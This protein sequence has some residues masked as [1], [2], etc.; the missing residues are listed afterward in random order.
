[1]EPIAKE[2]RYCPEC[3]KEIIGRADKTFCS[4]PCRNNYNN[5][6]NKD[7][8]NL[9]R[10]I[11]NALRRNYKIMEELNVGVRATT[12]RKV[13]LKKKFDFSVYTSILEAKTGKTYYVV[14][15]LVYQELDDDVFLIFQSD[16]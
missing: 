6:I 14:Y 1:M 15:D 12:T 10:N 11:N 3:G 4:S 9:M 2:K 5:T 7:S 13:L 8:T 16:F